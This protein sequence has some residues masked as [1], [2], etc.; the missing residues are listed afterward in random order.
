MKKEGCVL[1]VERELPKPKKFA[2]M[3]MEEEVEAGYNEG[4]RD[5]VESGY[6]AVESLK[7]D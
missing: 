6:V 5:M 7:E 4:Q 1:K 3:E 2:F